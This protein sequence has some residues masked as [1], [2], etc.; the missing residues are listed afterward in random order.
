M[1]YIR[2]TYRTIH[3]S[4]Y[5]PYL[6]TLTSETLHIEKGRT[7]FRC[8]HKNEDNSYIIRSKLLP[9]STCSVSILKTFNHNMNYSKNVILSMIRRIL[10]T[11]SGPACCFTLRIVLLKIYNHFFF[12]FC[13]KQER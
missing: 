1:D 2:T 10:R 13:M 11:L 3:R 8:I 7:E 4:F 6:V 9:L 12:P 5:R